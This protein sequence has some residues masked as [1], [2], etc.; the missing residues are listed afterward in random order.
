M[1]TNKRWTL[2]LFSDAYLSIETRDVAVGASGVAYAIGQRAS[3]ARLWLFRDAVW[4]LDQG[5]VGVGRT[6][7][8]ARHPKSTDDIYAGG[9]RLWFRSDGDWLPLDG[10][11]A[12]AGVQRL[13]AHGDN[14]FLI[15][16]KRVWRQD[17]PNRWHSRALPDAAEPGALWVS[18]NWV[19]VA[20]IKGRAWRHHLQ[21]F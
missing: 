5:L 14:L 20:S 4:H 2:Q 21:T 13:R 11:T 10:P 9:D 1:P 6:L 17:A 19:W 7:C 15:T 8:V 16:A 12:L 3:R 18:G